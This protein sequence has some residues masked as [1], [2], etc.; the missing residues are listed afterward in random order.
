M[1]LATPGSTG[2]VYPAYTILMTN[3]WLKAE[4]SSCQ[5]GF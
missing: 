4:K 2:A 3:V 1:V 5:R